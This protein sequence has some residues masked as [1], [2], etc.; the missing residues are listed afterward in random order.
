MCNEAKK[1]KKFVMQVPK[2]G[3]EPAGW[4]V[5][6][7]NGGSGNQEGGSTTY[8]SS[9][10]YKAA[11]ISSAE[12]TAMSVPAPTDTSVTT[13][14]ATAGTYSIWNEKGAIVTA[15][16]KMSIKT[17]KSA[18]N[19]IV[20]ATNMSG[21]T[22]TAVPVVGENISSIGGSLTNYVKVVTPVN[23][24]VGVSMVYSTNASTKTLESFTGASYW[25]LVT[26]INGKILAVKDIGDIQQDAN[27]VKEATAAFG[28]IAVSDAI[29]FGFAR[30]AGS[31]GLLIHSIKIDYNSSASGSGSESGSGESGSG[32]QGGSESG[33]G[34]SGS[35]EQGGSE[36]GSGES[37]NT[38]TTYTLSM[39]GATITIVAKTDGTYTA[40][41]DG[42]EVESG[43]YT[44]SADGKT[45]TTTSAK[46][47]T[48]YTIGDNNVLTV[49]ESGSGS[50][51]GSGEQ[52]VTIDAAWDFTN[53]VRAGTA[54]DGVS[55]TKGGS[56]PESE[57]ELTTNKTGS[58]AT[59]KVL[60]AT[61]CEWNG[62]LQFSTGSKDVDLFTITTDA[63]CTAVIKVGSASSSKT[64]GKVNALKLGDTTIYDFDS[65]DTKDAVEKTVSLTKGENKF[66]GSGITIATVKLSN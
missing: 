40:S 10:E 24:T 29:C 49:V 55:A 66:T 65:I 51:S 35:G 48:S 5:T 39:D 38:S 4:K 43:T 30:G 2:C 61:K 23:D 11:E 64:S 62:K 60:T 13:K 56:Q 3:V 20:S 58:G 7:Y 15:A 47:A 57:I 50:E 63:D 44:L 34:E 27:N 54:V 33:S 26:D 36:S 41:M 9:V 16:S 21:S 1:L 42:T 19:S 12:L 14:I 31:G 46:G 52:T 25:I 32:E 8:S 59:M 53:N 6:F 37:S 17:E 28:D 22:A 45:V 18:V